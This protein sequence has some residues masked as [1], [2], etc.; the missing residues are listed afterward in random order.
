MRQNI[1]LKL[2]AVLVLL[3]CSPGWAEQEYPNPRKEVRHIIPWGSGG[4]T[5]TAMR[6]FMQYVE[7]HLG[8]PV[9]T[10]NIPRRERRDRSNHRE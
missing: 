4:A 2:T 6:G 8:I 10:E 7:K 5:D 9:V 3:L 1:L